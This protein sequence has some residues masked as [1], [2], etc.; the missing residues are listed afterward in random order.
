[1]VRPERDVRMELKA[2]GKKV[3]NKKPAN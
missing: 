1:M 2:G 3:E